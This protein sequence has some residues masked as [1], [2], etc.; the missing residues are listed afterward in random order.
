MNI[1]QL[2][3][4]LVALSLTWIMPQHVAAQCPNTSD[5]IALTTETPFIEP[6][7][8]LTL[9]VPPPQTWPN[10]TPSRIRVFIDGELVTPLQYSTTSLDVLI[11][12]TMPPGQHTIELCV[13]D[14]P[15]GI[16]TFSVLILNSDRMPELDLDIDRT[17]P[18]PRTQN[19]PR[20]DLSGAGRRPRDYQWRSHRPGGRG[21]TL[22]CSERHVIDGRFTPLPGHQAEWAGISPMI[23]RFSNLYLDYCPES[24]TMY[25]MNDWLIGSGQ[26]QQNC[27]N[28]FGFTTG[29]GAE[30]WL[31]KVT[32]DTLRPVIVELNG[33]DVTDDTSI[34]RGGAFSM[35]PSPS[36]ST[37]HTMYEFGVRTSSGLFIMPVGDDPVLYVP[38]TTTALECDKDGIDR[39]GLI[40]EPHV[41]M[42]VFSSEGSRVRQTERYIP[43]SGVVGLEVEP[44]VLSG[45][46]SGDTMQYRSGTNTVVTSSCT[47]VINVDGAYSDEEWNVTSPASGMFSDIYAKYCSGTLHILN[48]WVHASSMPDNATCY[49]LFELYTGDGQ[50]HWGIWVWQDPSRKPTVFRN[51]KDVSDDTTIV[52]AGKAGWGSSPRMADP[53]ALYEFTISAMEGGFMMMY[54][55][56]G[57]SS[58]CSL[59]PTSVGSTTSEMN[60]PAPYRLF[61]NPLHSERTITATGLATGDYVAIYDLTGRAVTAPVMARDASLTLTLPAQITSGMYIVRIVHASGV[62]ELPVVVAE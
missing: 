1:Y 44:N 22:S 29:N 37:P 19:G 57:P 51:G 4:I 40:R 45:S 59:E 32:H 13:I 14:G 25:L 17:N 33:V 55:D 53:H 26:Y 8:V 56:P 12:R 21:G 34:V 35:G 38:S 30:A 16:M 47:S 27:Y 3:V 39:Y 15:Y 6:G 42:A 54:A 41:R 10:V 5:S 43:T 11:P 48:D 46:M 18:D 28:V 60:S 7:Q 49:N 24:K 52:H 58:F 20:Q 2:L 9:E 36:D 61:P 62:T 23:G 31:I 50:E